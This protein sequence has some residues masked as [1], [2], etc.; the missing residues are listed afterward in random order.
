VEPRIGQVKHV[1]GLRR[2]LRRGLEAVSTEWSLA[3]TAVN[4]GILL[5]H[6]EE[7]AAVL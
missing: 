4:L 1:L 7:V 2:F 6:W 5:S 3:C